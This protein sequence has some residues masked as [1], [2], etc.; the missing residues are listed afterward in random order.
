MNFEQS[1]TKENLLKAYLEES[2]AYNEYIFY[3]EQAKKDGYEYIH[4]VFK[5]FAENEKAHAKIWFKLF[6]GIADTEDNLKD[7]ADLERHERVTVYAEFAKTAKDEGFDDIAELFD[8]V[9][10][11]EGM[12]EQKYR[13]LH[14]R[15]KNKTFFEGEKKTVW[16]CANCGHIHKGEEPPESC[17][18][19]S[20]PTAYFSVKPEN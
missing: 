17:P 15:L 10:Q 12:H 16:I 4:D 9:A 6:H 5:D 19:C 3:A 11:I 18:I 1:K 13:E 2:G 8:G 14:E 7:A 20:Y